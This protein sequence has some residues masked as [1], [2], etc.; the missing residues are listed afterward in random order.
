[1]SKRLYL[2]LRGLHGHEKLLTT[3]WISTDTEVCLTSR[4]GEGEELCGRSVSW[5]QTKGQLTNHKNGWLITDIRCLLVNLW[6]LLWGYRKV[7]SSKD[8][9]N[10]GFK[11][12]SRFQ[13]EHQRFS[14][15]RADNLDWTFS[16]VAVHTFHSRRLFAGDVITHLEMWGKG[17][18][19]TSVYNVEES[20]C[21]TEI[22]L[23]KSQC[24]LYNTMKAIGDVCIS[25]Y[26]Q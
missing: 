19:G 10:E 25:M 2:A 26:P 23:W 3:L 22:S 11:D 8:P 20:R 21:D 4:G 18:E 14:G 1:M 12:C 15:E 9:S 24:F 16:S 17:C 13:H 6:F 5:K 7:F